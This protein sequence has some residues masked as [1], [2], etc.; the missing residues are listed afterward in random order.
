MKKNTTTNHVDLKAVKKTCDTIRTEVGKVVV[1]YE[2]VVDDFLVCLIT[3]G[4]MFMLG[5]P[6]IAKTTLAKTFSTVTGFSWSRIQ[7][8]QDLLPSD[9]IGHYY[10]DQ[11]KNS[12]LLRKG[13]VFNEII[14]A[15]EIN[16]APPKTQSALIEA[17]QE[18][19][20]TIEGTT[21]PLPKPFLVIATKNP[22]ETEGVYPLP[23][24]QLDRFLYRVS[25][26]YLDSNKELT[27][28]R[29]KNENHVQTIQPVPAVEIRSLIGLHHKVHVDESIMKYILDLLT[30]T[31]KSSELVLGGSPRAGEHLLYAAKAYALIHGKQ[32]VIPD[33]VKRIA[34]KVL[35]HRLILSAEAEL[36]G[37]TT[38][39]VI[40]DILRSVE[41]P[42]M[43]LPKI[44]AT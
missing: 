4:H 6:G 7:F 29:R 5:I 21:L 2:D 18:R 16:R 24:A 11:K 31:R 1:G 34:P 32:Y 38:D 36:E 37:H 22:I 19:Q 23:E 33:D 30:E 10:F 43:N 39:K 35:S 27:M 13:P 26:D 25:M 9:I 15:D 40:D 44:L 8:T 3:Q 20:V 41:I 42:E 28:L 14:L 12:F 17:M